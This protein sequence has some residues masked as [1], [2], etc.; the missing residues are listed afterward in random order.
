MAGALG[1]MRRLL[2]QGEPAIA[3]VAFLAGQLRRMMVAKS[4]AAA[5][6]PPPELA[7]RLGLPPWVGERIRDGARRYDSATLRQAITR[8]AA[9][10][11]TLKSSRAPAR[12]VLEAYVVALHTAAPPRPT[13]AGERARRG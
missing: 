11:V 4:L 8:L 3:M 7:R 9:L 2:D 10:D 1:L 5:D 12:A 13:R 6:C